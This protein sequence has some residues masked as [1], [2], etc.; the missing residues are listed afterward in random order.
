MGLLKKKIAEFKCFLLKIFARKVLRSQ[1]EKL[2]GMYQNLSSEYQN[3]QSIHNTL[4]SEYHR[5]HSEYL[6][7]SAHKS[8]LFVA[9]NNLRSYDLP[10]AWAR[11]KFYEII[12]KSLGEKKT[13]KQKNLSFLKKV[14]P[15][16]TDCELIRIGSNH[17]GG[18]LIPNDLD[19]I[20]G[21]FSPGVGDNSTFE[22]ELAKSY[23]MHV[24]LADYSVD[25]PAINNPLFDFEKKYLGTIND[26]QH[27][28]LEDWF[29]MK[30]KNISN[31]ADYLLQMDIEGFEY[32]ILF[33]TPEDI[34]KKFRI[35]L[36]EFHFLDFLFDEYKFN[37]IQSIFDKILKNFIVVHIHPNNNADVAVLN[38]IEI[39]K[40][41]E[42]T[43]YR[44]DRAKMNE[45]VLIFPHIY[46]SPNAPSLV[47]IILPNC[48]H[49]S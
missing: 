5:L 30:K 46:D 33:D 45:K 4:D 12:L 31:D 21:C 24:F 25:A 42:F 14:S 32:E 15:H 39:P 1:Y 17:D 20:V 10:N 9:E 28:R 48:W 19:G 7:T 34:L 35:M 44:R 23:G 37:I 40:I 11:I 41:M 3:L 29:L 22:D 47:D 36:I 38:G 26:T 6:H 8:A 13:D 43:F 18:Y 2:E 49:S 27:I 16:S